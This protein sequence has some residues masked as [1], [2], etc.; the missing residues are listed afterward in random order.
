MILFYHFLNCDG[1]YLV[2]ITLCSYVSLTIVGLVV[3]IETHDL[4]FAFRNSYHM[5]HKACL[6]RQFQSIQRQDAA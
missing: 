5:S 3:Q 1:Y 2:Y 4:N 6:Q